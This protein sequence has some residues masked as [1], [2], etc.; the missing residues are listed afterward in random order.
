[1]LVGVDS[2]K[3]SVLYFDLRL[4]GVCID[5]LPDWTYLYARDVSFLESVTLVYPLRD[6]EVPISNRFFMVVEV[7]ADLLD[8]RFN[9]VMHVLFCPDSATA[10]LNVV[11]AEV[12]V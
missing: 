4:R 2:V 5:V 12:A 3:E 7:L 8:S 1:L 10:G 9:S 6:V 11:V